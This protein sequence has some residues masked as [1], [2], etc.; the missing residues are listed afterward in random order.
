VLC[1]T[2]TNRAAPKTIKSTR[3]NLDILAPT[4]ER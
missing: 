1:A 2:D 4:L 3:P